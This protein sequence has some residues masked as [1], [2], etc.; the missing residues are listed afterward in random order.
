MDIINEHNCNFLLRS[1]FDASKDVTNEDATNAEI[2]L[3]DV[4]GEVGTFFRLAD[5][6]FVGGSLVPIGGHN[7]YEPVALGKPVLHGSFMNNA[8]EVR[9]FL[10]SHNVAFEVKNSEEMYNTC[11]KLLSDEDLLRDISKISSS[12]TK[13]ES[14]KQIDNVMQLERFFD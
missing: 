14:L 8:L 5:V 10:K 9:D 3:I 1:K 2:Y 7:I 12:I 6:T 11:C 13:N 4:F